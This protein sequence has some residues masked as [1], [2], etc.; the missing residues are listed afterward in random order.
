MTIHEYD[1]Y[2]HWAS[3]LINAD[4]SGLEDS[5]VAE[6]DAWFA[7][8]RAACGSN[9]PHPVG[10]SEESRFGRPS[11]GGLPGDIVTYQLLS[12]KEQES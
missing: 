8:A 10:C 3:Y 4:A 12:E 6:C 1:G 7:R 11:F 5:D 2:A 9:Y